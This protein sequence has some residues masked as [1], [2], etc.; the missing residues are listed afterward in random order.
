MFEGGYLVLCFM[1]LY[2]QL[3]GVIRIT[4]FIAKLMANVPFV[5]F[6]GET[7]SCSTFPSL[8]IAF[9]NSRY[10]T[11]SLVTFFLLHK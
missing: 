7:C 4:F 3:G 6:S 2:L 1:G 9:K 11:Q 10:S 8:S 5:Y